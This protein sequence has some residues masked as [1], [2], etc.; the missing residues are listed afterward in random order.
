MYQWIVQLNLQTIM[1][2]ENGTELLEETDLLHCVTADLI[3]MIKD[4][5]DSVRDSAC[6]LLEYLISHL[7]RR[8]PLS[9]SSDLDLLQM[10]KASA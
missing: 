6:Q 5:Y 7:L 10:L 8:S 3:M 2:V 4:Y 9:K 1:K